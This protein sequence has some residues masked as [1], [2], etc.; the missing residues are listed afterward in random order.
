MERVL[1]YAYVEELARRRRREAARLSAAL[2]QRGEARRG[3]R[4]LQDSL[5]L[6]MLAVESSQLLV[7]VVEWGRA[8]ERRVLRLRS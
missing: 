7:E 2:R 8:G 1:D 4:S 3:R 5:R 6:A